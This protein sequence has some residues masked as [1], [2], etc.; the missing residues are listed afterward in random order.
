MAVLTTITPTG[1]GVPTEVTMTA[2]GSSNTFNCTGLATDLLV[3]TTS[4]GATLTIAPVSPTSRAGDS[5][6]PTLSLPNITQVMA[7]NKKYTIPAPPKAYQA[8]DGTVTFT[9]TAT[10][11]ITGAAVKRVT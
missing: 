5:D 7:T 9:L 1:R 10:T 3:E 4:T 11:G 6:Y 8:A 2:L